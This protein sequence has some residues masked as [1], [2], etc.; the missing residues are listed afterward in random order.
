MF[1][2]LKDHLRSRLVFDDREPVFDERRFQKCDWKDFYPDAKDVDPPDMPEPKGKEVFMSCFVDAYHAG[3]LVTMRSHTGMIIF[4][5]RAPV[6]WFSKR[7]NTV[8][9]STFGL[10]I[11][12]LRISIE[13]VEGLICK[14]KMMGVPLAGVCNVFCD[15]QSVVTNITRP[16]SPIKKK[17]NSITYHRA[18]EAIAAEIIRVAKEDSETNLADILTK[19]L[20]GIRL[21]KLCGFIMY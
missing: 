1:A 6:L 11:V 14:L 4:L 8:E 17:H 21:S 16:E 13:L 3:C 7:Q 9:S 19:L 2:Y 18:R 10:E 12:A 5:K 15:N 20:N